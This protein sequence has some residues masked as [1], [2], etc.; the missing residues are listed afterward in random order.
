MIQAPASAFIGYLFF[1]EKLSPGF[2][3]G[4]LCVLAGG[5]FLAFTSGGEVLDRPQDAP[6]EV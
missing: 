2:V 6:G 1:D 3:F 5:L 4:A